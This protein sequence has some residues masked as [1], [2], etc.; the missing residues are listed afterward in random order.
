MSI[1]ASMYSAR[2]LFGSVAK[3]ARYRCA[4]A[5]AS[6]AAKSESATRVDGAPATTSLPCAFWASTTRRTAHVSTSAATIERLRSEV[7]D[8]AT[9][10]ADQSSLPSSS[11]GLEVFYS[12]RTPRRIR[13]RTRRRGHGR[14]L[15]ER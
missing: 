10:R 9:F 13:Q 14:E 3:T 8:P 1:F 5:E 6:P 12:V 15:L 7:I 4:A 11:A 2:V